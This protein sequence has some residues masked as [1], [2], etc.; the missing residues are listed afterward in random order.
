M[1]IPTAKSLSVSWL[2]FACLFA[3]MLAALSLT[4]CRTYSPKQVSV[5]RDLEYGRPDGVSLKLDLY[6]PKN[7]TNRTPVLVWIHGGAWKA[8]SR[9]PCPLAFLVKDGFA[10]VSIEYRFIDQAPFPAQLHDC[11]GAIRWIKANAARFNLDPDR[12]AVFGASAGGHL[13]ALLGTTADVKD[14][15]GEVGGNLE[16]TSRVQAICAFYPPT[17][18]NRLI[19]NPESRTSSSSDIGKLLGGP[20]EANL[21]K[22]A[23]ANPITYITPN[24]T[25][26][27][28][29]HG[30]KDKVVPL[31]QSVLL[32]EALLKSGV[33]SKLFTVPNKGHGIGAPTAATKEIVE[34]L[35][36]HLK[37]NIPVK[38]LE[39][40]ER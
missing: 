3:V 37:T 11:K 30:A 2:R 6:T 4:G 28:I 29:L 12:I 36:R 9:S 23:R 34:F 26:F 32:H 5:Q 13:A 14:L 16:Q 39:K 24:D 27:Y 40:E 20:L 18:L 1:A 10:A 7:T 25:P 35:G 15:E 33:E 21:D 22:A 17:D 8:G 31:E 19:T 38:A